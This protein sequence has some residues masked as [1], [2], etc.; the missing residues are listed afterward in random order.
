MDVQQ[1]CCLTGYNFIVRPLFI[2]CDLALQE[3]LHQ[4][5]RKS[6]SYNK[7]ALIDSLQIP[8]QL[9]SCSKG[10]FAVVFSISVLTL[11][12]QNLVAYVVII[13]TAGI[14]AT[15]VLFQFHFIIC[16]QNTSRKSSLEPPQAYLISDKSEGA[17]KERGLLREIGLFRL[18]T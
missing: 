11:L 5:Q 8:L 6:F 15:G 12:L 18:M 4:N 7:K 13:I 14:Q 3:K 10:C 1:T 16:I 9:M 2:I 17:L